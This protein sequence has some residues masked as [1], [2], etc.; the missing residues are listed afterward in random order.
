ME[1]T[2]LIHNSSCIDKFNLLIKLIHSQYQVRCDDHV[3]RLLSGMTQILM[4][5]LL[6]VLEA[7]LSKLA[8]YD[9]GSLIGSFL[10]F[11]V[12]AH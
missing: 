11:T 7:T 8:R 3:D 6:A 10:S 5:R 2:A 12:R 4:G 1:K 9:E